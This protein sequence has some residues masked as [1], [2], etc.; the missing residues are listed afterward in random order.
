LKTLCYSKPKE[1]MNLHYNFKN[2]ILGVS[3]FLI[4]FQNIQPS[5]A[6]NPVPA[7]AQSKRILLMNGRVHVGNGSVI[8]NG[9]VGF[10]KGVLDLVAD[11]TTIRIDRS[12]YDTIIDVSGK[13][14]YP[15][16]IAMNT[17]LGLNEI[18][19]VRATNDVAETGILNPSVR[20][21]IAYNTDSKVIPTVRSNG[22]L[23]AQIVPKPSASS[24]ALSGQSSVVVL[25]AWNYE[26]A[27]Y[28]TDNGMHLHWPNMRIYRT[29]EP[30]GEEKQRA[31]AERNMNEL[32]KL[33]TEAK[34]YANEKK[35]KETNIHL[36]S[37][38]GV[39]SGKKKLF[40]HC[41]H[42]KEIIAAVAFSK[43]F[44]VDIVLVGAREALAV[45]NLLKEN[46]IPVVVV[47]THRLPSNSDEGIDLPY[48]FPFLLKQAGIPFAISVPEFWQVRNLAYQAGSA[49][50][51]GLT[52]EE[53]IESI[54]LSP[55]RILGIDKTT[56]SLEVGKDATLIVCEGDVM[57]MRSSEVLGAYIKGR[58]IDLDNI[59]SQLDRKFRGKYK[60]PVH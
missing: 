40:I 52:K 29:E 21:I 20:S 7:A 19:A 4:V 14:V 50:A 30:G 25:D 11:A 24:P 47:E 53:A 55:A 39:F 48:E 44:G 59:Q 41:N 22:V 34:A 10:A 43:E 1:S 35:P 18:E 54:T 60:L 56:G 8:E 32:V 12:A 37:M 31:A 15:G 6:Q 38:K 58:S 9:A 2:T 42:A 45:S 51:Y 33:F 26:D 17:V 57:D 16:L 28:V 5:L 36:E 27:A 3:M 49:A 46:R 23:M 13:D